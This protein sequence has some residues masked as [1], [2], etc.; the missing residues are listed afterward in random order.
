MKSLPV[1]DMSPVSGKLARFTRCIIL[2]FF[3]SFLLQ[4]GFVSATQDS[5]PRTELRLWHQWTGT[6]REMLDSIIETFNCARDGTSV[7]AVM[8]GPAS[9][10]VAEL[11]SLDP[12]NSPDIALV[13]HEAIPMLA[14]AGLIQPL[15]EYL[16]NSE[17]L[18]INNLLD[19]AK[20]HCTYD[21]KLYGLPAY[22]NPY[23]LIY[24]PRLLSKAGLDKT[25][26]R[27]NELFK[28][29][30]NQPPAADENWV[31]SLRSTAIAFEILCVQRGVDLFTDE[32]QSMAPKLRQILQLIA[33]L[34]EARLLPPH[35]KF[36]APEFKDVAGGKVLFQ[37]DNVTMLAYLREKA[38]EPLGV[39]TP[40]S[41]SSSLTCLASG[42]VFVVPRSA[43]N[44]NE[45]LQFLEFFFSP[46]TYSRLANALLFVSPYKPAQAQL[47][48]AA[49]DTAL[50][51]QLATAATNAR[52]LSLHSNSARALPAVSRTVEK[53]D[54][55]LITIEQA[56]EEILQTVIRTAPQKAVCASPV[57]RVSWADSTRRLSSGERSDFR[58][59][60]IDLVSTRNEHECVQLAISSQHELEGL[61]I[62]IEPFVSGDG[63]TQEIKA[64]IYE[65]ID[66]PISTALAADKLG[67][68]PNMLKRAEHFTAEPGKLARF[69]LDIHVPESNFEGP[70]SSCVKVRRR[71]AT[72]E[73]F[74]L[75]LQVVPLT[76][77]SRPSK[78]AV[79]GLNYDLISRHYELE[80][81]S[82]SYRDM[83]D[84]YYW[85]VV[86]HRL[87]PYQPP[88][89]IE[90]AETAAYLKDIRVS[91]L[92]IPFPPGD[93]RFA[94][95]VRLARE[96]GWLDKLYV[97]FID[98]PT[99]HQYQPVIETG[100]RI[101]EAKPSPRFLVSCFPDQP[102]IGSVDIWCV[103]MSF[104]PEG[105]P[106]GFADRT[107]YFEKV[108]DRLRA[109]DD[110]WWYTAGAIRPFPTLHIEDDPAAFRIMPWLQELSGISG[111]LHWEAAF[112]VQPFDQP[113]IPYFG[114]GEG[115]LL[116]PGV[117]GPNPSIRLELLREGLEDQEL[118][119][120]MRRAISSVQDELEAGW[121]GQAASVRT[122][123]IC[124]SLLTDEALRSGVGYP[125]LLSH[126]IREP[127]HIE[128]VREEVIKETISMRARPLALVLT[129]PPETS[130][131]DSQDVRIF[132]A[133][134]RGTRVEVNGRELKV[135]RNDSFSDRFPLSS[136][137]NVF[138]IR[139]E[140]EQNSKQVI[141]EILRY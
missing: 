92:R 70:L 43:D 38:S 76:L 30:P 101:H 105:I 31:L 41:D 121:L 56:L 98:E 125:A 35:H 88:V 89:P 106:R 79:V 126:F 132:G 110:V 50:Y 74:P 111:F 113:F 68:Y 94:E 46:E 80:R 42:H 37:L 95:V 118:L 85:F 22:V 137:V 100:K 15:D 16:N 129:D 138:V 131:T 45:T 124:R 84:S 52:S 62:S 39:A 13:E 8:M 58:A 44:N 86:D 7:T 36:W 12:A 5:P 29:A 25:P 82:K 53:L 20:S 73:E 107:M 64:T 17:Q 133:V 136:G 81:G 104:L 28:L 6:R 32:P 128:K 75:R 19:S 51:S 24:N 103:L 97:Y 54:A 3:V 1:H 55:G 14:D 4:P 115:T 47:T 63:S 59:P 141:R 112:W 109:G 57:L 91:G 93:A 90:S 40:P 71:G 135:G 102:L 27:W 66:T 34:R 33:K 72:L 48:A 77:P 108:A 96:G 123:E 10:T 116:Y 67:N 134:E 83:M 60:P 119:L 99:Y 65:Q 2:W 130:Y 49:S 18:K 69:W 9:G 61:S 11:L 78:P 87:S 114:N 26:G 21:G 139:L 120:L 140:K 127:G 117:S 23:V 122:S